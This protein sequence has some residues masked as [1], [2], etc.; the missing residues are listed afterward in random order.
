[1]Y[2]NLIA[3]AAI[4]AVAGTAQAASITFDYTGVGGGA[5][6]TAQTV[7]GIT[8]TV[9]GLK[10]AAG[11]CDPVGVQQWFNGLGIKA[12]NGWRDHDSHQVD[13]YNGDDIVVF[14]FSEAVRIISA[15]F[16]YVDPND[17]V[18]LFSVSGTSVTAGEKGRIGVD[19]PFSGGAG[20]GGDTGSYT[21]AGLFEG[22]TFGFGAVDAYDNWK[23][24]S[25]T[26]ESIAAVPLPAAGWML[27]AG[28][29]G[30]AAMRRRR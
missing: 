7:D 12:K 26:V 17:D 3:A 22:E 25:V 2:K 19:G 16:S 1:M 21:F 18:T 20:N 27:L 28:L 30:L 23:L 9:S 5:A 13:G 6:P 15:S 10:C 8:A 14:A 11:G 4:S 24:A 29:G